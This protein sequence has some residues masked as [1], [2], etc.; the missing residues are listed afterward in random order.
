MLKGPEYQ[1]T[2]VFIDFEW[3]GVS[4]NHG[5]LSILKGPDI[6]KPWFFIDF[7]WSGYQKTLVFIVSEGS[8][9]TMVFIDPE[10]SPRDALGSLC[11]ALWWGDAFLT[12]FLTRFVTMS[13]Q[14]ARSCL[15]PSPQ[16]KDLLLGGG[17]GAR[18]WQ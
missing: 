1:K 17:M 16:T 5:F 2:M 7:E 10:G 3:S 6:K 4:K 9:K 12:R 14:L 11:N 18:S 13:R 15:R 8:I